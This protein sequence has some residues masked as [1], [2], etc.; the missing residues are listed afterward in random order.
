[1]VAVVPHQ[2]GRVRTEHAGDLLGYQVEDLLRG[3]LA[4][5]CERHPV[6][7]SPFQLLALALADVSDDDE[8][9]VVSTR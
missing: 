7:G 6:E 2:V 4:G 3:G 8:E 5:D 1:M 9:L